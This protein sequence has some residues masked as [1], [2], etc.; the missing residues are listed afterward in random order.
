MIGIPY[1]LAALVLA[2]TLSH[3]WAW[4]KGHSQANASRDA[5][6]AVAERVRMAATIRNVHKAE[7]ATVQYITRTRTIHDEIK[8]LPPVVTPEDDR[9]CDLPAD[10]VGMWN[11][12]N[13]AT[14]GG[15][16]AAGAHAATDAPFG[17]GAGPGRPDAQAIGH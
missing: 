10:F 14:A 7:A 16:A 8:S 12:T 3:G 2:L 6:E 9:R 11:A 15:A 1:R 4:Y 13:R 17:A 5:A